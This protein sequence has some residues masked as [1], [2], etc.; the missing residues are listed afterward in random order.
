MEASFEI[1]KIIKCTICDTLFFPSGG[2]DV[3]IRLSLIIQI[4]KEVMIFY[5]C[6]YHQLCV[7][8][9]CIDTGNSSVHIGQTQS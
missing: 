5:F 4:I 1:D 7:K 8:W 6:F 3:L 2:D 9:L